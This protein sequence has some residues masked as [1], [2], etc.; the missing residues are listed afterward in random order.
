VSRVLL[1]GG[2]GFLGSHLAEALVAEGHD[3]VA[4]VRA[5]SNTRWL[6]PLGIETTHIELGRAD[7][8]ELSRLL[9]GFDAV[10]HCGGLTRA[11]T[12]AE[13]MAVNAEG[14]ERLA[15]AARAAGAGRFVFISSLAARGPDG[16]PGPESPYGRSKAEAERRLWALRDDL[17]VVVLRP[18]GVYGPR[19]SDLLPLFE[20]AT[21]GWVVV[22]RSANELQPV[23]VDD[24]ASATM[25][26][27]HASAPAEPLPVAHSALHSWPVLA[28]ALG[29]AVGRPGRMIRVPSGV[30]WTAGLISEVGSAM[31]GKLPAMDRRKARDLSQRRWTCDVEGTQT[32]L[33]WTPEVDIREGLARTAAW[34]REHGWL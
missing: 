7:E 27:L 4:S 25:R 13:F 34:Y 18:G 32:S 24:V 23:Y 26:A 2:T 10:V 8:A 22:P 31:T 14:T 15:R 16:A 30:F 12:E 9:T 6:D 29:E 19:D 5:T 21:K 20:M 1:T 17:E 28:T 33:V 3:L 11:R